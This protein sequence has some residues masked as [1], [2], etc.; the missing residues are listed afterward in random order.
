M[1]LLW[2]WKLN[3]ESRNEIL[4]HR[5]HHLS[6]TSIKSETDGNVQAIVGVGIL[7][8]AELL[9][10]RA[11]GLYYSS[12][13]QYRIVPSVTIDTVYADVFYRDLDT[14]LFN[15]RSTKIIQ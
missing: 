2:A 8:K 13:V 11:F 7:L 9:Q 3:F 10:Q 14:S 1:L 6:L 4:V 5:Q 12:F 15:V